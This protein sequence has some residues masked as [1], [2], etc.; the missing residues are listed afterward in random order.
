MSRPGRF[1]LDG[2]TAPPVF[3]VAREVHVNKQSVAIPKDIDDLTKAELDTLYEESNQQLD[4]LQA[5]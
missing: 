1:Q 3:S 2:K 4:I 5:W